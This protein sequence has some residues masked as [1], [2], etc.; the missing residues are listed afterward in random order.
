MATKFR[1]F[2]RAIIANPEKVTRITKATR[3]LH[4]YLKI[5]EA[6]TPSSQRQYCP[7]GYAD[8]EDRHGYV[9]PGDWR[10][11]QTDSMQCVH[12]VGSHNYTRSAA[13]LRDTMMA[14]FTSLYPGKR[15][16]F[17]VLEVPDMIA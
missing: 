13:D 9:I 1:I 5:S 15:I 16:M 6:R 7:P 17:I 3:S 11:H 2:R 4:N 12:S 8:N 14:Y 10:L